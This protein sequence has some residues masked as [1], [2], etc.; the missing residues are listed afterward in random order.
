MSAKKRLE[1]RSAWTMWVGEE[2]EGQP[3]GRS[4][5][6]KELCNVPRTYQVIKEA[7][8]SHVYILPEAYHSGKDFFSTY[9][10]H[11]LGN[12]MVRCVT[13][14][15]PVELLSD[16]A[17]YMKS[18]K[19]RVQ[20]CIDAPG[21]VMDN[22]GK[23]HSIELRLHHLDEPFTTKNFKAEYMNDTTPSDYDADE[24]I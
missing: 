24:R 17:R 12:A 7:E 8:V 16:Y 5:F 21:E 20:I 18:D 10:Y 15:T 11:L 1:G 22:I 23:A 9:M 14:E 19:V 13:L 6:V 3:L 4:L 2:V